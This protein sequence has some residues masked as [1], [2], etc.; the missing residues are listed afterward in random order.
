MIGR[1]VLEEDILL[2]QYAHASDKDKPRFNWSNFAQEEAP[3]LPGKL[4]I[5]IE[6]GGQVRDYNIADVADTVGGA[7]TDLLLSRKEENIFNDENQKLVA[8]V[9]KS[10]TEDIVE[11]SEDSSAPEV[12][13]NSVE[14]TKIIERALVKNNAHDVAR[15]LIMRLREDSNKSSGDDE[16]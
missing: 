2:K 12:T 3:E 15:S 14:L 1:N 7:L 13:F 9:A 8:G 4:Q 10:V 6:I 11:Q 16:L 5:K